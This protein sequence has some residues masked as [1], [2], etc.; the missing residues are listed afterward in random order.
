MRRIVLLPRLSNER[1][2]TSTVLPLFIFLDSL[3]PTTLVLSR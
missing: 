3:G 2:Q 1:T